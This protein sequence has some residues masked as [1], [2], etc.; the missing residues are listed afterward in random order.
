M[1]KKLTASQ[2]KFKSDLNEIK[3]KFE[4]NQ[5]IDIKSLTEIIYP[6]NEIITDSQL[7][8]LR[9]I[10]EKINEDDFF[11]IT[12]NG[13][14]Y[15]RTEKVLGLIKKSIIEN[16]YIS[17]NYISKKIDKRKYNF[18]AVIHIH[19]SQKFFFAYRVETE[20]GEHLLKPDM[21]KRFYFNRLSNVKKT[22]TELSIKVK[23]KVQET[24]NKII[25]K[26]EPFDDFGYVKQINQVVTVNIK[27]TDYF[28][29]K[30][31]ED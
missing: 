15:I 25:K 13:T 11:Q 30:F 1:G 19:E 14:K 26:P 24:Q 6:G 31:E 29:V 18:I 27:C 17:F 16:H 21:I 12:K 3:K 23:E 20:S 9:R 7:R 10:I 2:E 28:I 8:R 5:E 22:E 4:C